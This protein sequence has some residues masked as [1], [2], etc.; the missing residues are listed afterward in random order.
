MVCRDI[1]ISVY[2]PCAC[3]LEDD[4]STCQ[5]VKDVIPVIPF[6][7]LDGNVKLWDFRL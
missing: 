4:R 3:R 6:Y 5:K 2:M 7:S 1:V